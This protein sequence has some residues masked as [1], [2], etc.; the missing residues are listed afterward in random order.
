MGQGDVHNMIFTNPNDLDLEDYTIN[1]IL[2]D[3]DKITEKKYQS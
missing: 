2:E 3:K 1:V